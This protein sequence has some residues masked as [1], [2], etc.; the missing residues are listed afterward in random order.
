MYRKFLNRVN[1][2]RLKMET[3]ISDRK[4]S[5]SLVY[6]NATGSTCCVL[7]CSSFPH[8]DREKFQGVLNFW[9][10]TCWL[11]CVVSRYYHVGFHSSHLKF[12]FNHLLLTKWIG[13]P[14][15][16][17]S[18]SIYILV[19]NGTSSQVWTQGHSS[20]C[21]LTQQTVMQ[22]LDHEFWIN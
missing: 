10:N 2:Y 3:K 13:A 19:F 6:F 17:T 20:M 12:H 5:C 14:I 21:I 18:D 1:N 16:A 15:D 9:I 4:I 11:L 22:P 8:Y 7:T